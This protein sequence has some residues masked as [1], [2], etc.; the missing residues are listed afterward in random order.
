MAS[1]KKTVLRTVRMTEELDEL[2]QRDAQDKRI[3]V[4]S[5]V[6][7]ILSKYSEWDRFAERFGFVSVPKETLSSILET[8]SEEAA[9]QA[10]KALGAHIPSEISQFWMKRLDIES[11]L[12]VTALFSRYGGA[13]QYEVKTEG[14]NHVIT[15]HHTMGQRWSAY[16][17]QVLAEGLRTLGATPKVSFSKGSFVVS[18]TEPIRPPF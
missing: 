16:L 11:F 17:S 8:G 6:A 5:L 1:K 13:G 18:F 3:S 12:A 7:T 2:L 14:R 9:I 10:G 4:N 15:A